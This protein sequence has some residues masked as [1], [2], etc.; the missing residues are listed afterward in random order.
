[1]LAD[2]GATVIRVE[3]PGG[4][5]DPKDILGRSRQ[6]VTIDLRSPDGVARLRELVRTAD[7]L[8]EGFRPGVLERLGVGP[9][10]LLA[11]NPALVIGR[12]TGWGQDGPYASAPGH[13]IN[14]IALTGALN[15]MRQD[16]GKPP[17][18]LNLVGDFGGGGM[19]LAFGM[20][21]ALLHAKSSGVGQ[22]VDCAMIDGVASLMA[23]VMGYHARGVWIDEPGANVLDGGCHFYQTYETA[24]G[25]LISFASSEPQFYKLLREKTGTDTD[26]DFDAQHDR[27]SWP[28]LTQK[29]ADIVRGKTSDEWCAIMEGTDV[30][31]APVLSL[32]E[33]PDHPHH[34]ARGTYIQ[35]DGL[36]QPAPAP[37]Y[38]VTH[39]DPPRFAGG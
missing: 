30:C 38:S 19:M 14:Y 10:I 25:K 2:N 4:R 6:H 13:D 34:R 3:R 18:P 31:F 1:M 29:L 8:I 12:M 28:K 24:D 15:S 36:V 16:A 35:V 37:R 39:N 33:A 20:V 32:S 27:A 7:G 26:P 5:T 22:V 9:E 11:E 17:I 21:S 23:F